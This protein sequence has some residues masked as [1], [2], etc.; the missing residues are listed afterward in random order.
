MVGGAQRTK[1]SSR[2][3]TGNTR[4]ILDE[5]TTGLHVEDVRNRRD[6]LH[7]LVEQGNT[8]VVPEGRS[9]RRTERSSTCEA[10]RHQDRRLSARPGPEGGV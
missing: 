8:V 1:G 7:A 3:A 10:R 9:V 5:P 4:Y 6:V 2:R